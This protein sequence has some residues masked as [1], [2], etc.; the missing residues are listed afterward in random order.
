MDKDRRQVESVTIKAYI[1]HNSDAIASAMRC[2]FDPKRRIIG[3]ALIAGG[4][5]RRNGCLFSIKK[6][7][8]TAGGV[9]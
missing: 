3:S 4:F 9:Q 6:E 7:Y 5:G 8:R 2:A 1:N